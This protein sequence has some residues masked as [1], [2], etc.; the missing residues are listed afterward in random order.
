[1]ED[2]TKASDIGVLY[3]SHGDSEFDSIWGGG[4]QEVRFELLEGFGDGGGAD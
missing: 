2:D 3:G 1:M 4:A